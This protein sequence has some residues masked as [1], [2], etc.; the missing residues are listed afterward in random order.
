MRACMDDDSQDQRDTS[1]DDETSLTQVLQHE[2]IDKDKKIEQ[3]KLQIASLDP[4]G[5]SN[6]ELYGEISIL[7]LK[8]GDSR[9]EYQRSRQ[10][11]ERERDKVD[12]LE[13]EVAKRQR[14]MDS[15]SKELREFKRNIRAELKD[16]VHCNI[17]HSDRLLFHDFKMCPKCKDIVC[18][19]C[20]EDS[21]DTD[22]P[23]HTCPW[24]RHAEL[25]EIPDDHI[26][27]LIREKAEHLRLGSK[28][29]P[30]NVCI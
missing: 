17:C 16:K 8:L 21:L 10:S 7:K 5:R 23:I 9:R 29:N 19:I 24:C 30:Y 1:M 15:L 25:V 18:K 14:N 22:H 13:D 3:L 20:I 11:L 2:I 26:P 28:M 6:P 12:K 4:E 27:K